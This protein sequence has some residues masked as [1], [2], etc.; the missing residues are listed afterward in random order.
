[1]NTYI[2]KQGNIAFQT[3]DYLRALEF[4]EKCAKGILFQ[5]FEFDKLIEIKR[6]S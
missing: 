6:K 5:Q 4:F 1:M 3:L 2:V